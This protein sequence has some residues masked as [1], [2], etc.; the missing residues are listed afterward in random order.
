MKKNGWPAF[1]WVVVMLLFAVCLAFGGTGM[2]AQAAEREKKED[3]GIFLGDLSAIEQFLGQKESL[4]TGFSFEELVKALMAGNGSRVGQLIV[5]GLYEA[6]L[7]EISHGSRLAGELLAL[8]LIGAI[9]ANFSNVFSGSQISE[10]GFFMTYL[11]VFT[12]LAAAFSDSMAITK[13]VLM[14]QTEFIKVLLPC[15]FPAAAW[16]GGSLSSTAWM[17]FLLFLIGAVQ[18]LYLNLLLPMTRVYILLVMAG[19]MVREDMLSRLTGLLQ[20]VILWGIRSLMGLVLGFQLVQGLVLPY[21]DSLQTAGIHK[22]LQAIPGVG[23]GAGVVTKMVFGTGVLV[24]NTMG[25]AAVVVLVILSLLPLLKLTV[26]MLLYRFVSGILQPV[27]DKRLV[28]CVGSVADGQKLLLNL[29]ASGLFLFSVTIALICL[30]TNG[31]YVGM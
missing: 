12:V 16:A 19:N 18:W 1:L 22:L 26:L 8:G 7:G 28:S 9:F 17:E 3:D 4:K 31:A 23:N 13:D 2:K 27:G 21:A 25:A 29:A 10:T 20:S 6:L 24:K 15:Y 30:G 5:K 11:L 14:S